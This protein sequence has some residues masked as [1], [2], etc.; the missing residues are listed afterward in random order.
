MRRPRA[1][2]AVGESGLSWRERVLPGL[3]RSGHRPRGQLDAQ[4]VE[5]VGCHIWPWE[6]T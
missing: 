6:R 3:T 4:Y 1:T 5:P 2:A